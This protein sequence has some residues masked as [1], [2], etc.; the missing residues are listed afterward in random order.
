MKNYSIIL[1]LSIFI[2]TVFSGCK[3]EDDEDI[4]SEN[5]NFEVVSIDSSCFWNSFEEENVYIINNVNEL[6]SFTDSC[7]YIFDNS[8]LESKTLIIFKGQAL[9]ATMIS[10]IAYNIYFNEN[11]NYILQ[12]KVIGSAAQ[13]CDSR[14]VHLCALIEKTENINSFE[15][16]YL[17][18]DEFE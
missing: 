15:A 18:I 14:T 8:L 13:M 5:K 4:T 1:F 3:K 6:N 17:N 10:E 9:S 2:F 16:E 7:S 12:I 11:E